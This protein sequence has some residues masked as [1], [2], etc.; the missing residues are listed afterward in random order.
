MRVSLPL[1]PAQPP[2]LPPGYPVAA[3][4]MA[5]AAPATQSTL[6]Y[7]FDPTKQTPKDRV[8]AAIGDRGPDDW[9]RSD[10]EIVATVDLEGGDEI[11]ATA[12]LCEELAAEYA[13][14][15]DSYSESG[16]ISVRWG[17]RIRTW[18]A[19]AE[20]LRKAYETAAAA[21]GGVAGALVRPGADGWGSEYVRDC[22]AYG[23]L[24]GPIDRVGWT[25]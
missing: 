15:I 10:E 2:P 23:A 16:G 20:N 6:T 21:Q 14:R 12:V 8:R 9:Q 22:A 4:P 18:L 3:A 1:T 17:E 24:F 19:L 13:K 5:F 25:R 7:T 11:L